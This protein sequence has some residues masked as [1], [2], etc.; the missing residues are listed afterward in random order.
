MLNTLK[1][2]FT[3]IFVCLVI[4]TAV[5]GGISVANLFSIEKTVNGMM[6]DNYGSIQSCEL[7]I[8]TLEQQNAALLNFINSG[9]TQS[10]DTFYNKDLLFSKYYGM[11]LTHISEKGEKEAAERIISNYADYKRKVIQLQKIR[12]TQNESAAF[13][14]YYSVNMPVFNSMYSDLNN[15]IQLNQTSMLNSKTN[16]L[17]NV[18][19]SLVIIFL[20]SICAVA[21]GLSVSY[22]YIGKFLSP[23]QKLTKSIRSLKDGKFDLSLNVAANDEI[24]ELSEEFNKLTVRLRSYEKSTKGQLINER[25][26]SIAIMKSIYDPLIVLDINYRIKMVNSACEDF[27][28]FSEE[29]AL[30]RHLLDFIKEEKLFDFILNCADEST[31]SQKVIRIHKK[32]SS[33]FFNVSVAMLKN[34]SDAMCNI[35]F[36]DV[37]AIEELNQAKTDFIATISHEFKT[38][39]TAVT[40]GASLLENEALG[41]LNPK[42]NDLI[43]TILE[44]AERLSNFVTELLEMS[45]LESGKS[46]YCPE[47]CS[48]KEISNNS[49]K[50][51]DYLAKQ[52]DI[53]IENRIDEELP[54]V[55]VDFDKIT[56]VLNNLISN[57]IKYSRPGGV[58]RLD[59]AGH[60]DK[61][62]V[63]VEDTGEG[64]PPEFIDRVFDKYVQVKTSDIEARGTGLGLS[65]AKDIITA[66]SGE[67]K[68]ESELGKGSRFIFTLPL[69]QEI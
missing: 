31:S 8:V 65:V 69:Y 30:G 1:G 56:W 13:N 62:V 64:I 12:I 57:A 55:Y 7:M 60:N 19:T 11:E 52:S 32:D 68:V 37:T 39:L 17:Q 3:V 47:P 48:L 9:S 23:L 49:A 14:Y 21:A 10:I 20:M 25:N 61:M 54:L 15:I 2:K 36:H 6:T 35:L 43:N 16:T 66:H 63:S 46:I 34:D 44:N 42:Q 27:F 18:H 53:V 33:Y 58:I 24:G 38:P 67:I 4:L 50:Q 41:E 26:K 51:F 29:N 22:Y 28:G 5:V 59:A 40:M 45:K